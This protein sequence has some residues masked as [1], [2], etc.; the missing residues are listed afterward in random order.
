MQGTLI[1]HQTKVALNTMFDKFYS[2][3]ALTDRPDFVNPSEELYKM[4]EISVQMKHWATFLAIANEEAQFTIEPQDYGDLLRSFL[5]S[6][7]E[8]GAELIDILDAGYVV[9]ME[10]VVTQN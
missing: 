7:E 8:S 10:R 6:L 9:L 2:I 4:D 1:N 3:S 5:T